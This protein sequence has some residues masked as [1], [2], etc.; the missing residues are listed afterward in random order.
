M[1]YRSVRAVSRK[2]KPMACRSTLPRD[3]RGRM[4]NSEPGLLDEYASR[5]CRAQQATPTIG[6]K[7]Y[8]RNGVKGPSKAYP[9]NHTIPSM[10]PS[11]STSAALTEWPFSSWPAPGRMADRTAALRY[12]DPT[13]RGVASLP[14]EGVKGLFEALVDAREDRG[15]AQGVA[16]A[17]GFAQGH[18]QVQ[19]VF[20]LVAFEGHDPFLVIQSE[21][22]RRVE[23]HR[24]EPVAHFDVFV[25][26]A[27]PGRFREEEPA[28]G[29]QE[30]IDED[31]LAF[32]GD[33][34][35]AL[36]LLVVV[37]VVVHIDGAFRHREVG[38]RRREVLAQRAGEDL[39]GHFLEEFELIADPPEHEVAVPADADRRVGDDHPLAGIVLDGPDE[40]LLSLGPF[41]FRQAPPGGVDLVEHEIDELAPLQLLLRT[42]HAY[43]SLTEPSL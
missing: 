4:G 5:T 12:G 34:G 23:L 7:T 35:Q 42:S 10:T 16:A 36:A 22:V 15:I 11:V 25:H 38:V 18:D 40:L 21:G 27:L 13:E 1:M 9:K 20:R 26:H 19:E 31:V 37:G 3:G 6:T 14:P 43:S 29:L 24:R 39:G 28:A 30:R 32:S 2:R 8:R 17:L 41:G 33:D